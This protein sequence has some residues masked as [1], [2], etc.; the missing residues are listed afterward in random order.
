MHKI[1]PNATKMH[2]ELEVVPLWW[3]IIFILVSYDECVQFEYNVFESPDLTKDLFIS[4]IKLRKQLLQW[5]NTTRHHAEI[6]S[7]RISFRAVSYTHLTL[8]TKA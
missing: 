7:T 4:E 3:G 8:P 2:L 6:T 1:F 5:K